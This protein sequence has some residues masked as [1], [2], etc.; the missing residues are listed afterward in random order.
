MNSQNHEASK[1]PRLSGRSSTSCPSPSLSCK[2]C[3][4]G[5]EV[6]LY[7]SNSKNNPGKLFWRCPDWKEK[8]TCGIFEWDKG[9]AAEDG[10]Q[11]SSNL[12]EDINDIMEKRIASLRE[13]VKEI[14]HRAIIKLC[15]DM[16]EKDNKIE[17]MKMKL[18]TEGLKINVLLFFLGITLA[19]AVSKFF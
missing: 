6:I 5:K 16:N 1:N 18:E 8:G 15:E 3:G 2:T 14:V 19:V 17:M 4:C 7:R 9:V 10:M 11:G 12:N 13:D